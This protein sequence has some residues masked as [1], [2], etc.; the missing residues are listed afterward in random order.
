VIDTRHNEE[1]EL[2]GELAIQKIGLSGYQ[3]ILHVVFSSLK[4]PTSPETNKAG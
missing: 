1:M 3:C 4:F 2:L